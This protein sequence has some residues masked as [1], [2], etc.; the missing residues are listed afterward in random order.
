MDLLRQLHSDIEARVAGIRGQHADWP[1][2]KGC[3]ACCRQ[4]AD[5]PWLTESEWS[6]LREGLTA[7]P[8]RQLAEI[9]AGVAALARQGTGPY[10]CPLLDQASGACPVYAQRPV[11]CRS[12]GFYV[13]RDKGLYCGDIEQ[14]VTAGGLADVVWGN[15]DGVDRQLAG[16]G[17]RRTLVE[18]FDNWQVR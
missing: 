9:R 10:A 17:E 3:D 1:C 14:Q 11:A 12:Y 6:L 16:L 8:P 5:L 18:W 15:H 4:L 2:A 7:L 13:Q